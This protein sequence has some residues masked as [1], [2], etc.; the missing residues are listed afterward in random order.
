MRHLITAF[1]F[2]I[3]FSINLNAEVNVEE[4]VEKAMANYP[5]VKKYGLITA[6]KEIELSDINKS[7]LPQIGIYGQLTAQ[8]SVPSFPEALTNVLGNMG[9]S[10]KGLD[11]I[12]YK[13][14]IDL[15]QTLWDGGVS[16]ARRETVRSRAAVEQAAVGVELYSVRRCV[17]N[18][19]FAILLTE[20]QIA[21]S[22]I[23][24]NVLMSN[25]GNLRSMLRNG[26]A[27]QTD[28]DMV[29]AQALVLNQN[30]V[31]ARSAADGYRKVLELYIGESL[32]GRNLVRPKAE[33]PLSSESNRPELQLFD[34][35][36]A[37][38]NATEHLSDRSLFPKIGLFAQTY[39]GY[40]G[41]DYFKS[42]INRDL[43]FNL[44]AGVRIVW[45]IDSFYFKKNISHKTSVNNQ[46]IDTD[47]EMFLFNSNLQTASQMETIKGLKEIMD[48][49]SRIIA[50]RKNVR[51]AAESQLENGIIDATAL[52]AKISDENIAELTAKFHEIQLLQ[53][54]YRLKY[55]LNR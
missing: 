29:E 46:N 19:Y 26:T 55:T 20:E 34:R 54:I 41:F 51:K 53:E 48:N 18:L 37:A 49:D 32:A 25:L 12:Q 47:R 45:N 43:S 22:R 31:Q 30:I 3:V 13:A 52:L 21:Q 28:L 27:M 14:G 24:Y 2:C 5:I 15:S 23:T 7:W 35:Q 11:K 9:Q 1:I 17:E 10:F 36:I 50:L 4:C 40:P 33:I 8:N 6:T 39:Y 44:I 42:M 16:C 38:N